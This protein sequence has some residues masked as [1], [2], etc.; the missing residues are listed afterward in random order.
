MMICVIILIDFV[1]IHLVAWIFEFQFRYLTT[2]VAARAGIDVNDSQSEEP[3]QQHIASLSNR[4]I[5]DDSGGGSAN[6]VEV[7]SRR[8]AIFEAQHC[9]RSSS[10]GIHTIQFHKASINGSYRS[11]Y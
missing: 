7:G 10:L 5:A 1:P 2:V 4:M 8:V 11:R 6:V 9:D 3:I